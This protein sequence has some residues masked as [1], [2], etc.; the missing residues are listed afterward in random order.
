MKND[1]ERRIESWR[2]SPPV[3]PPEPPLSTDAALLH[4]TFPR[5]ADGGDGGE[6][7]EE[8][9]DNDD[10]NAADLRTAKKRYQTFSFGDY[11]SAY[12]TASFR[13]EIGDKNGNNNNNKRRNDNKRSS[14]HA[15]ADKIRFFESGN[16]NNNN[17]NA[18]S[19]RKFFAKSSDRISGWFSH[20]TRNNSTRKAKTT[21]TTT[22]TTKIHSS[23][24]PY[25]CASYRA[26]NRDY[27]LL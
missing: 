19:A 23:H 21:T 9:R 20:P 10:D 17:N 26:S 14:L 5:A 13:R 25:L 2:R 8:K 18:A 24:F 3:V 4:Q 22:T 12:L 6:E 15:I 16:N 27:L 11:A 1:M 7:G